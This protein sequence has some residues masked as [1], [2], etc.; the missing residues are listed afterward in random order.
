MGAGAAAVAR[1]TRRAY[2]ARRHPTQSA[3]RLT[4]RPTVAPE[5]VDDLTDLL[6][7][8]A[9]RA[10]SDDG[11][12]ITITFAPGVDAASF[13]RDLRAV[14]DRWSDMHPGVRVRVVPS[15]T[16][17]NR[18]WRPTASASGVTE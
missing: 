18:R 3:Y 8:V 10:A 15:T 6:R 4:V 16:A 13:E 17:P 1:L 9:G 12:A 11:G 14:V 2:R 7:R 5:L